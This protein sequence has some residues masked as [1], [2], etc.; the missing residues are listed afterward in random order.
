M[1]NFNFFSMLFFYCDYALCKESKA[2]ER[3]T[4]KKGNGGEAEVGGRRDRERERE[5]HRQ[6]EI[7]LKSIL[8]ENQ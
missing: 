4:L 3:N 6:R 1:G 8:S 5:R 7:T 2:G